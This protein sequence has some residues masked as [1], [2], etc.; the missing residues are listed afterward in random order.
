MLFSR[1]LRL[2]RL[3]RSLNLRLLNV[4]RVQP[5]HSS[6][7]LYNSTITAPESQAELNTTTVQSRDT[8]PKRSWINLEWNFVWAYIILLALVGSQNM[9][10]MRQRHVYQETKRLY[11]KKIDVLESIIE[12]LQNGETVDIARELGTGVATAEKEWHELLSSLEDHEAVWKNNDFQKTPT[13][14]ASKSIP[15][16][17]SDSNQDS[18]QDS[19]Q[20]PRM[21][22]PVDKRSK[23]SQSSLPKGVFL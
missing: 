12:R 18:K 13:S 1:Y 11:T 8:R 10:V 2:A 22:E 15:E 6:S 14:N 20:D 7:L 21:P 9:N 4:V 5:M 23:A 19:K 17:V 3:N 16:V